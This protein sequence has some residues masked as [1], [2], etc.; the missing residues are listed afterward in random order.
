MVNVYT[1]GNSHC[2]VKRIIHLIKNKSFHPCIWFCTSLGKLTIISCCTSF[3]KWW[4]HFAW[5]ILNVALGFKQD[6]NS[7]VVCCFFFL[8]QLHL[9]THSSY[10]VVAAKTWQPSCI[11][12]CCGPWD[13]GVVIFLSEHGISSAGTVVTGVVTTGKLLLEDYHPVSGMEKFGRGKTRRQ[14][15]K[16]RRAKFTRLTEASKG[17]KHLNWDSPTAGVLSQ[18]SPMLNPDPRAAQMP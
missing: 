2:T 6:S 11:S 3:Y 18:L 1:W 12:Q 14:Q 5:P 7:M 17:D 10:S 16:G 4:A 9:E 15:L 13:A 8:S